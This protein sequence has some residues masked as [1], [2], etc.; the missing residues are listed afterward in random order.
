MVSQS[1]TAAKFRSRGEW[2][3]AQMR[4]RRHPG[5]AAPCR[6]PFTTQAS[7]RPCPQIARQLLIYWDT[8]VPRPHRLHVTQPH[9]GPGAYNSLAVC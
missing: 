8:V 7:P 1:D 9:R 2:H 6:D 5:I 3:L 4:C